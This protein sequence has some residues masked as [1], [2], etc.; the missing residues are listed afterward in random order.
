MILF[1]TIVVGYECVLER[2]RTFSL[3]S[4]LSGLFFWIFQLSLCAFITECVGVSVVWNAQLAFVVSFVATSARRNREK[5][6][7]AVEVVM[8]LFGIAIDLYYLLTDDALTSLAHL[9]SL[10]L[11]CVVFFVARFCLNKCSVEQPVT[12]Y[13][14]LLLSVHNNEGDDD[15]KNIATSNS[16]S[17]GRKVTINRG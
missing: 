4:F 13:D 15:R 1:T 3:Q 12:A 10:V 2:T 8:C 7:F 11:G 9:L 17:K 5:S 16:S 6:F 14:S